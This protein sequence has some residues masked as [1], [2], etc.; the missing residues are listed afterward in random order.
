MMLRRLLLSLFLLSGPAAAETLVEG[1]LLPGW[2]TRSG[3]RMAAVELRLAPGWKT[4]W[5][6]PGEAGIPPAFD[7][8]GS[9]NLGAVQAHWP[10]PEVF[11][12]NGMRS[13]GFADRLVLPLEITPDRAGAP[14]TIDLH[15][16][17]GVCREVCVPVEIRLEGSLD[18][19]RRDPSIAAA[20]ADGPMTAEDAGIGPVSCA[21]EP[22]GDGLRI[23]ARIA[24][25]QAEGSETVVLET[26]QPGIWVSGAKVSRD[27]ADLVA[28]ADMV[29][30]E[31]V[32]FALDRQD[33]RLT[34]IGRHGAAEIRGCPAG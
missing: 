14:V 6:A 34:V 10:A 20:L 5:R 2:I 24:L 23:A 11:D 18:G 13:L 32:P 7:W 8:S 3:S 12:Q 27:G 26:G 22:I 25:P 29:P 28:V 15:L 17:I 16:A 31:G 21:V 4:Y 33:L 30:Q 9:T 19:D 1:R